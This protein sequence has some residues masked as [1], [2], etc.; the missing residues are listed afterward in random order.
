MVLSSNKCINFPVTSRQ[1]SATLQIALASRNAKTVTA[2]AGRWLLA[3]L[4]VIAILFGSSARAQQITGSITG[5]VVD[6]QGA[7][8]TNANIKA[9]NDATGFTRSTKTDDAG[10][11]NIQYLPIGTY[12]VNV[13]APGFKKY[14]QQ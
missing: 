13:D 11:Y 14:V 6:E 3:S 2:Q 8:V 10:G 7:L 1:G 12:T 9:T 4:V 5:K